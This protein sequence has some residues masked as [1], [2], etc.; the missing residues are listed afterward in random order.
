[1]KTVHEYFGKAI[2]PF[3]GIHETIVDIGPTEIPVL[4]LTQLYMDFT[5]L[6]ESGTYL[7]F[8][9]QTTNGGIRD[10]Q[11]FHSYEAWLHYNTGKPVITY[12]IFT[13]D[14]VNPVYEEIY[15]INTYRIVP[16]SMQDKN[17]D[18]L[19]NTLKKK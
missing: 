12:V 16:I 15:G 19:L 18:T 7:H 11:R 6:T 17:A 1:M 9:F 3:L 13:G 2:L 8:E 4:T 10:L 14:I 5:F